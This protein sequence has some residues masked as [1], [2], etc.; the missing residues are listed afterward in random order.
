MSNNFS[1]SLAN[2]EYRYC[3]TRALDA[4]TMIC[5]RNANQ[6]WKILAGE[7]RRPHHMVRLRIMQSEHM[8]RGGE[9]QF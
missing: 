9:P 7:R 3:R 2:C 6:G 1:H 4:A 5:A 8:Q